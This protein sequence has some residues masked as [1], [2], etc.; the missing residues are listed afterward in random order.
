MFCLLQSQMRKFRTHCFARLAM[1]EI[2]YIYVSVFDIA[3]GAHSTILDANNEYLTDRGVE[4]IE[5]WS[6][7]S[8]MKVVPKNLM[9]PHLR[10]KKFI[11]A[12]GQQKMA[13]VE[14]NLFLS[15]NALC[16]PKTKIVSSE[17]VLYF[18]ES[19]S[20][21]SYYRKVEW[22]QIMRAGDCLVFT[23]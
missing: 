6:W 1:E 19:K 4:Y 2:M 7:Q 18:G 9:S 14:D 8:A 3:T 21:P 23:V 15:P 22:R 17:G 11:R 5:G 12:R 16:A 20:L 10:G 13:T